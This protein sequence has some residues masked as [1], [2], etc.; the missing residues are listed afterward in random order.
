MQALRAF[1]RVPVK[2]GETQQ[3]TIELDDESFEWFDP[4]TNTMRP[5]AGEYEVLYG[6]TS[7]RSQ[8]KVAKVTYV[9]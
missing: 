7:D 9:D 8:L 2:K 6:G 4:Q 1:K 5:L 3:V